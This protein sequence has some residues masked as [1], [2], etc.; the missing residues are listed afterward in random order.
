AIFVRDIEPKGFDL[1]VM[2]GYLT[3]KNIIDVKT[4]LESAQR[5]AQM[6]EH[7]YA[8]AAKHYSYALLRRWLGTLMLNFFG[9]E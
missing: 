2:D 7:N 8:V 1:V 5:R 3:K 9:M 6:V 4:I